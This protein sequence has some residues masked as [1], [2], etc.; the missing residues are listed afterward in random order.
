MKIKKQY[1]GGDTGDQTG[2]VVIQSAF[3][4]LSYKF[5]DWTDLHRKSWMIRW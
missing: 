2:A 3:L 5:T 1:E 4:Y